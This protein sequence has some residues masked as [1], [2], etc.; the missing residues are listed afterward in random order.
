MNEVE[1]K[2]SKWL[3]NLSNTIILYIINDIMTIAC[4]QVRLL[5]MLCNVR[6]D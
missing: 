1:E 4:G 3:V 2:E 6:L 5:V